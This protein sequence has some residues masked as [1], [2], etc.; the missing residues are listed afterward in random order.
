MAARRM[1]AQRWIL[2][3]ALDV[4]GFIIAFVATPSVA[5]LITDT[6]W[7]KLDQYTGVTL[8]IKATLILLTL[9]DWVGS[10]YGAIAL[11]ITFLRNVRILKN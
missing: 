11:F 9:V 4:V 10:I 3:I 2:F 7:S 1:T 8:T 5:D 6:D